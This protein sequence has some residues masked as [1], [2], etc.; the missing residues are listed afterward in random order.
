MK[1]EQ[2]KNRPRDMTF[3]FGKNWRE[4]LK[5]IDEER[6][7]IARDSLTDFLQMDDLSGKSFLDIGCG[8]GLFSLAAHD[9]HAERVVSFDLDPFSVE[10]CKHLREKKGQ[11]ANWEVFQ[12]SILDEELT[13]RLGRFDIVYSWGVLHHT[14]EMWRA[15]ENAMN[16]VESGGYMYIAIYNKILNR[17]GSSQSW[18]H[19]FWLKVKTTYNNRP[20]VGKTLLTPM[21]MAAYIAMVLARFENP[22]THIRNY[23]SH[24]GMSW[25]RDATDWIGG[26]PYEFAT[27]EEIF[28]FIKGLDPRFSLE[29]IKVTSGRGLNWLL[30]RKGPGNDPQPMA[31]P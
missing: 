31:G 3:E 13:R 23:K 18:I 8:S 16:L 28:K 4:F 11:P 14:G 27:V 1:L 10:C 25:R 20:L 30:F 17:D 6:I 5:A 12:A 15:M 24:R 9:L 2:E 7:R 19:D 26:Y 22:V 21:A 29:N